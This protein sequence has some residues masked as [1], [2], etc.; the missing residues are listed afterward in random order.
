VSRTSRRARTALLLTMAAVGAGCEYF[1]DSPEQELANRR[2]RE[3]AAGLHDVRLERVDVD[4]RIR[5]SYV[6]RYEADRVVE[7]LVAAGRDGHRLPDPTPS[8]SAGK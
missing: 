6:G 2:W 5:F 7:C 4:G 1:R 8:A 3:C